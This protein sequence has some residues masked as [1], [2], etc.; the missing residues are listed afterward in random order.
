MNSLKVYNTIKGNLDN[1]WDET[2]DGYFVR[3]NNVTNGGYGRSIEMCKDRCF[4]IKNCAGV[5]FSPSSKYCSYKNKNGIINFVPNKSWKSTSKKT[6]KYD[7]EKEKHKKKIEELNKLV[8]TTKSSADHHMWGVKEYNGYL[9][10]GYNSKRPTNEKD[11]NQ[12]KNKC[13][14]DKN[15][16]GVT[17]KKSNR[18]C[19]YKTKDGTEKIYP[20]NQWISAIKYSAEDTKN[21]KQIKDLKEKINNLNLELKKRTK[22]QLRP[23]NINEFKEKHN[24]LKIEFE[25]FKKEKDIKIKNLKN[26]LQ[27][28]KSK[29]QNNEVELNT[30]LINLKNELTK[31]KSELAKYKSELSESENELTDSNSELRKYKSDEVSL[32]NKIND[33]KTKEETC[34]KNIN[35]MNKLVKDLKNNINKNESLLKLMEKNKS[36]VKYLYYGIGGTLLLSIIFFILYLSK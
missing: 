33:L 21:K 28:F 29:R 12:C 17:F 30:K 1:L 31:S 15:C 19:Y 20:S 26:D 18:L 11:F 32:T 4:N 2:T 23:V 25:K 13:I 5:S 14:E 8:D 9:K 22:I 3:G 27:Q 16:A 36:N 10:A 7:I 6:F 24:K 34:K 35:K